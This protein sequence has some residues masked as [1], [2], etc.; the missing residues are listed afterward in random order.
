MMNCQRC[1]N[2]AHSRL[3]DDEEQFY[4]ASSI[5]V[6]AISETSCAD[7]LATSLHFLANNCPDRPICDA[8]RG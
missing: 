5:A 8:G 4:I 2:Y 7:Y 6:R 1:K 3:R